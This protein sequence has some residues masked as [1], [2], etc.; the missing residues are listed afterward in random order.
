MRREVAG[1]S[2]KDVPALSGVAPL[3]ELP[4]AGLEHL[5]GMKTRVLAQQGPPERR[6][7]SLA[8]GVQA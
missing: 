7:E 4:H 2:D 8:A 1:D 5:I 3:R 6:D